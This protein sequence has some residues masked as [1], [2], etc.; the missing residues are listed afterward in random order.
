MYDY[1]YS[2]SL[3]PRT[4]C[5]WRNPRSARGLFNTSWSPGCR[6]TG[7]LVHGLPQWPHYLCRTWGSSLDRT[8]GLIPWERESV[9]ERA[10]VPDT[11]C[12]VSVN[13]QFLIAHF[14]N[15]NYDLYSGFI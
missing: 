11:I 15:F 9:L 8:E 12:G 7:A 4:V 13:I 2:R 5:M 3:R 10:A 1:V 6:T 14:I